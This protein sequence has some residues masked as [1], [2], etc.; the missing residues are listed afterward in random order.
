M[1]SALTEVEE[2]EGEDGELLKTGIR[3]TGT[4][5]GFCLTLLLH[6]VKVFAR[7]SGT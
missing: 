6:Y 5:K 1:F 7:E 2:E 3:Y 4:G